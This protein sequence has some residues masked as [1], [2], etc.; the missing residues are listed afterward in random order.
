MFAA[1]GKIHTVRVHD[2]FLERKTAENL[3][4]LMP[5]VLE[6]LRK[7]WGVEPIVFTTDASGESRK[8]RRLLLQ[9]MPYLIVPDCYAHQINLIVGDYF[10]VCMSMYQV[11]KMKLI[12]PRL[13]K[14]SSSLASKLLSSLLG[15]AARLM[16]LL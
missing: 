5:E 12:V 16:F 7:E 13:T 4:K 2:A 14:V 8:A 6:I 9:L 1:K 3:L 15:Y 10:K 11:C